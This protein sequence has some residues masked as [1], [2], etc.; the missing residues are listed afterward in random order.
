MG[1]SPFRVPLVGTNSVAENIGDTYTD[2]R[3]F[4]RRWLSILAGKPGTCW[5]KM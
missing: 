1:W 5:T 4:Q 3:V 2:T